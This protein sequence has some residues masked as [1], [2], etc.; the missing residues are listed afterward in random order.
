[1]KILVFAKPG[2]KRTSVKKMEDLVPG[3]DASF[4][5]AVKEQAEAGRA[6]RAI[7]AA[8]AEHFSVPVSSV[9]I[10]AGHTGRKKVIVIS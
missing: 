2:A 7:E 9:R 3:F 10:V 1:M 4:S 6:N 5:V 8:L